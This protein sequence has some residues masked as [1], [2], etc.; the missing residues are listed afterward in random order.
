M[1]IYPNHFSMSDIFQEYKNHN[2]KKQAVLILSSL[3]VA[4]IINATLFSTNI[5][6]SLQTSVYNARPAGFTGAEMVLQKMGTG[7][8][9]FILKNRLALPKVTEIRATLAF[10]GDKIAI[11]NLFS[12]LTPDITNMSNVSGNA[13]II[14]K[15]AQPIEI[16]A[17]TTIASFVYKTTDGVE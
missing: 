1:N 15:F 12:L 13:R 16:P 17:N 9:M 6:S 14:I 10:D 8:D 2:R 5:F 7:S 11:K 4:A 3:F